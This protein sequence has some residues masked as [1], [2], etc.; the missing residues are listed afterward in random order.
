[1][2]MNRQSFS[3]IWIRAMLIL[4][5]ILFGS[6]AYASDCYRHMPQEARPTGDFT[7][8]QSA[9]KGGL[10]TFSCRKYRDDNN[11]FVLLFKG[12][13]SPKAIY[14][15]QSDQATEQ[16][17]I[18]ASNGVEAPL[19]CDQERPSGVPPSAIYRGT[20]VCLNN[21]DQEVPCSVFEQI[22][23]EDAK[24][25]EIQ[26]YLVFYDPAGGGPT[27]I[28]VTTQRGDKV[29]QAKTSES[30]DTF[31]AELA[32]RL[33]MALLNTACCRE[34][35]AAYLHHA[36]EMFPDSAAYRKA[37]QELAPELVSQARW[38]E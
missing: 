23:D 29:V 14:H 12:G 1:M 24:I 6:V 34:R 18:W 30:D 28:G 38:G 31:T 22:T 2:N 19:Y 11:V 10:E 3:L 36:Y 17:L 5:G 9:P 16:K 21:Q 7:L 20:G 13:P 27:Q 37:Y 15:H 35:G 25:P 32:Y 4:S 8:C 33:G 26:R